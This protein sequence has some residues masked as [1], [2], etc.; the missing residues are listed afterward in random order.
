MRNRSVVD[1]KG[2]HVAIGVL[3]PS[4]RRRSDYMHLEVAQ[5]LP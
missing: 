3:E 4:V 5:L 1:M 2:Y